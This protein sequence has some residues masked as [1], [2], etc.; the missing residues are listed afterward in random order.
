MAFY[1]EMGGL[2]FEELVALYYTPYENEDAGLWYEDIGW[3]IGEIGAEGV[4]FLLDHASDADEHRMQG[5]LLG[6]SNAA[7]DDPAVR[8][9]LRRGLTD[10]RSK[11]LQSAIDGLGFARVAEV[12]AEVE[13]L[14]D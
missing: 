2:G 6:C 13:R 12:R 4:A 11:V 10:E 8:A 9:L 14:F 5:I 3:H 7:P 1:E